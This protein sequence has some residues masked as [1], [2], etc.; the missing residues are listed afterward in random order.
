MEMKYS[1]KLLFA[2]CITILISFDLSLANNCTDLEMGRM[3]K[4]GLSD[5]VIDTACSE[6]REK[7]IDEKPIIKKENIKPKPI[8]K[9]KPIPK[10]EEKIKGE[11]PAY[12]R[13]EEPHGLGFGLTGIGAGVY[14]DYNFS[15]DF[16]LNIFVSSKT[17]NSA[18]LFGTNTI[19]TTSTIFGG[20]LRYFFSIN[21]GFFAGFGGGTHSISQ[22]TKQKIY[23]SNYFSNPTECNGYEGSY[24]KKETESKYS[25]LASFGELGWQGYQGYYFT[26]SLVCGSSVKSSEEDNTRK[27][28]DDSNHLE[29][30]ESQW[31]SAK[32]VSGLVIG[33]GWR[34]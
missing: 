9:K 3:I 2:S 12:W 23:C 25:G 27:V 34:F 7:K 19:N 21:Y 4:R 28:I 32:G 17:Q 14:Y 26:V 20:K 8:A 30:A 24:I 6:K 11:T 15:D 10:P 22:K 5:E 13:L 18:S 16:Q 31:K 1:V 29:T 33:V